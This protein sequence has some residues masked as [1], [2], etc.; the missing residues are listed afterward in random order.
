M[1]KYNLTEKKMKAPLYRTLLN[2]EMVEELYEQI[3]SKFIVEK[4]YRD[5]EYS[6]Q[7]LAIELGTNTRYISAV[8]NLRYQDNYSQMVN[9]F[10][11]KDAMYILK[12][13]H[14]QKMTMKEIALSVGFSNR[15]SFYAAFFK[16]TGQSPKEYR[17]MNA[18]ELDGKIAQR[19]ARQKAKREQKKANKA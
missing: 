11:I 9:E 7:K 3:M 1:A 10:R 12:D 14:A 16:R 18:L 15:Q 4:K 5:P 19:R 17:K 2:S 8:I 13:K 6:A